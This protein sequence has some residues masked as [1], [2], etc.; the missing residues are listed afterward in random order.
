MKHY[1]PAPRQ[2]EIHLGTSPEFSRYSKKVKALG[3]K[4]TEYRGYSNTRFVDLPF[5]EEGCELANRLVALF[6]KPKTTI[7]VRGIPRDF[8][9]QYIHA[10]VVVHYIDKTSADP[11]Q[12]LL[13][14]YEAAFLRAFPDAVN[15]EPV[16]EPA[17]EPQPV[18]DDADQFLVPL[19]KSQARIVLA[20]LERRVNELDSLGGPE[21]ESL[22]AE[23]REIYQSIDRQVYAF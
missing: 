18:D 17:P 5:T 23:T 2:I 16:V 11:C 20:A 4:Y 19:T 21:S 9:G 1:I 13:D 15:P 10:P 3:G 8:R 22:A 7:I 12:D 14:S 6:G